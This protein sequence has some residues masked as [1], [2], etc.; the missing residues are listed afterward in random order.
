MEF[1]LRVLFPVSILK[2]PKILKKLLFLGLKNLPIDL[3]T[4]KP[5]YNKN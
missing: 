3:N 5:K 4:S 1:Y 2:C